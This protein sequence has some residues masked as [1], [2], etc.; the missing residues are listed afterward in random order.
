MKAVKHFLLFILLLFPVV[1]VFSTSQIPDILIYNGDTLALFANPLEQFYEH[2]S[3]KPRFFGEKEGCTS[4]GCWRGYQAEWTILDSVLY[5]NS[6]YSCCYKSDSV[7]ADLQTL[8][9][10]AFVRGSVKANWFTGT[11]YSPQGKLLYYVHDGYESSYENEV[12]FEFSRGKLVGTK[13]YDN[14]KSRRSEFSQNPDKLKAF[15][16]SNLN[17][18]Y[19]PTPEN[20]TIK[21]TVQ[22]SANENG[23]ID[24]VKVLS[25]FDSQYDT[26][27]IRVIKSIPDW[28]IYYKHGKHQR[29]MWLYPIVFSKENQKKYSNKNSGK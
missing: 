28:D 29:V 1:R 19:L 6:I 26:E 17:W 22:F 5:L 11:V 24:S 27:A 13:M 20:K 21:V 16:Y 9:G 18:K 10:D 25:G 7:K 3:D 14:S 15:I 2:D 8:F 23:L 12:A 4:T